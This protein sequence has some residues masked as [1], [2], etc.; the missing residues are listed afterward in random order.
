LAVLDFLPFG[1]ILVDGESTALLVNRRAEQVLG[2]QDGLS[3]PGGKLATARPTDT[4]PDSGRALRELGSWRM[5]LA[6]IRAT[7]FSW[8]APPAA[9]RW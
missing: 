5:D 4:P 8:R 3:T 9:S 7:A 1:I 6:R 2:E